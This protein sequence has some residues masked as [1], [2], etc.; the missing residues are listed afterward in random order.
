MLVLSSD[1]TFSVALAPYAHAS[2]AG[3]QR[4]EEGPPGGHAMYT[5]HADSPGQR[6]IGSLMKIALPDIGSS[7]AL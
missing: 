4:T 6:G 7:S 1:T 3:K 2:L 5:E